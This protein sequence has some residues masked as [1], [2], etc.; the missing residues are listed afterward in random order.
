M[1]NTQIPYAYLEIDKKTPIPFWRLNEAQSE[2]RKRE[3][4]SKTYLCSEGHQVIPVMGDEVIRHWR[5]KVTENCSAGE[6]WK[7]EHSKYLLAEQL[8]G[9]QEAT[10]LEYRPDVLVEHQRGKIIIEVQTDLSLNSYSLTDIRNKNRA[11]SKSGGFPIWFY[12]G[13]IPKNA[14]TLIKNLVVIQGF[15]PFIDPEKRTITKVTYGQGFTITNQETI[16]LPEL[17][18]TP[19]KKQFANSYFDNFSSTPQIDPE[20]YS[21]M[22]T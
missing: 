22:I 15:V 12:A 20:I 19:F 2:E 6:S 4:R 11:Y 13:K 17:R 1:S 9:V 21:V 16:Q 8:G 10:Y 14:N 7:H 5:H 3:I 18:L